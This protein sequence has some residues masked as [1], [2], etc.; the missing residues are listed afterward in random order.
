MRF[1]V[2]DFESFYTD[3]TDARGIPYKFKQH[4]GA[5]CN[6][7]DYVRHPW[8]EAHGAAIKWSPRHDAKW[9]DEPEL[10]FVLSQEDWSDVFLICHHA[11]FD[12]FILNHWYD[13]RPGMCGCTLS[14]ARLLLGNHL[15]VSLDAVR[16][17][18][19]MPA[20]TTPYGLFKGKHWSEMTPDVRR[21]VAEGA[22]DEVESIWKIFGLLMQDFPREELE[23]VDSV[24]RM[25]TEPVLR[26]DIPLLANVWEKEAA[27]KQRML[28]DLN[29]DATELQSADKF[30]ALLEAEGVEI[31][32]KD[33][34]NG[35]IPAFAKTD[36]FMRDMLEDSNDRVRTLAE[37]RLGV[38]STF[39]QTRAETLGWMARRGPLAVYLRYAGAGTLR[40][41]GGDGGNWLN[42][43]RNSD[44]RRSILAPE[45]YLIAPIDSSQI[46]CRVLNYL[47]GQDDVIR[48]FAEGRDPY[49]PLAS[50][51]Y[52][53]QVYKPAKD[54][55]RRV[56]METKRGAGKQGE[57]MCGYG[58]AGPKFKATAKAGLY[59]PPIDMTIEEATR[60]VKLYRD[61]HQAVCGKGGYW[62]TANRM[63]ARIGGG[64]PLEWGPLTI[65]DKRIFLPNGC[66]LIYDTM[67]FHRPGPDE[68]CKDFE[69]DGYW[70]YKT[71]QG[72]RT[73]WGAKLTQHICEA[74]SRV[75]VSQAMLRIKKK[76][77]R[78][79]NWPYDELLLLIPR[80]GHE[81]QHLQECLEEL[82]Q[83]PSWLPGLPL[84]C[85]GALSDRYEK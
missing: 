65:R 35:P 32:Y 11:Q 78:T 64:P 5:G 45:G 47:A 26:G 44:I 9:Y 46:E 82:R 63:L 14:M 79:L 37:A 75:I 57:L 43:K 10:R 83:T 20:K 1:V 77:I 15:S 12:M 51:F 58:A 16:K 67:E 8:F 73:M 22:C 49:I 2:L 24:I 34:K 39:L 38:K 70:R 40:V 74:V 48:N 66:P 71:R 69:R 84:D 56:E 72:W 4:G 28:L 13:V 80:D 59:G 19:G 62:S 31:E 50:A 23:V 7:E 30:T 42:F 33:G 3:V 6:T 29:I 85:E 81:D 21:Q 68:P 53:E 41:A 17:H 25:F 76:G 61:T 52:G 18:F 54:D 55:P 60:F 36:Q 27:N